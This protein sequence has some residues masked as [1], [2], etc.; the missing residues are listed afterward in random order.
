M[1]TEKLP[2]TLREEE[3]ERECQA[4]WKPLQKLP[5]PVRVKR[6]TIRVDGFPLTNREREAEA[7]Q[8]TRELGVALPF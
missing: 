5:K 2:L 7:E 3:A 6:R 8:E 4:N 1:I